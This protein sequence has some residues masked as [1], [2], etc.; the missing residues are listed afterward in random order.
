MSRQ[1]PPQIQLGTYEET[2]AEAVEVVDASI[3]TSLGSHFFLNLFLGISLSHLWVL[4]NTEQIIIML[5][6]FKI[7][8]PSNLALV[9]YILMRIAAIDVIPTDGL[10]DTVFNLEPTEPLSINFAAVGFESLW[11]IYNLG[12]VTLIACLILALMLLVEPTYKCKSYPRIKTS[13]NKLK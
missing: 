10:Y 4:I 9:F 3:K 11:L 7:I 8:M 5:P 2:F 1:L 6:L 13:C 12:S